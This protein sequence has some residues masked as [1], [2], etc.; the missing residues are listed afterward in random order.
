MATDR[1]MLFSWDDVERLPN[2]RRLGFVLDNLPDGAVLEAL[3]AKR[4]RGRDE[5][6]V[7][8]M[9]R[10]LVAG[11][12]FGHARRRWRTRRRRGATGCRRRG[13]SRAS[14]PGS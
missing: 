14:W 6:P 1:S 9:W 12:V 7:Q 5:Y 11:L 3:R 8:A 10:A 13:R 2:L 4:G